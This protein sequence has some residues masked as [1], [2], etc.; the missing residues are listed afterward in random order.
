[1]PPEVL[2]Q[3]VVDGGPP[4]IAR[5]HDAALTLL[6]RHSHKPHVFATDAE[7]LESVRQMEEHAL[8]FI[9]RASLTT[10]L[11]METAGASRAQ[12]LRDDSHS[13]TR[14]NAWLGA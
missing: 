8:A 6:A 10:A 7:A 4:E 14:I 1:M 11:Q 13:L 5:A 2:R 12:L 9:R 3:Q